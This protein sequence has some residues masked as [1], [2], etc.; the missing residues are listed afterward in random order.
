VASV[1]DAPI[2]VNDTATAIAG[3]PETFTVCDNDIDVDGDLDHSSV[4]VVS[5]PSHG[6]LA[7]GDGY[8]IYTANPLFVGE[9]TLTYKICDRT[10]LC[11]IG[12]AVITVD[13]L[14]V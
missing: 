14:T 4:T 6:T 1:A 13:L 9:D 11:A 5:P 12:K 2:A 3:V 7:V 10:G 8:V